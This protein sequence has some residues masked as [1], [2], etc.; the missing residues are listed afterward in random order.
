LNKNGDMVW[1]DLESV[2][3]GDYVIMTKGQ[4]IFGN[5]RTLSQSDAEWLGMLTGDGSM[6]MHNQ[7]KLTTADAHILKFSKAYCERKGMKWHI[8]RKKTVDGS[9]PKAVDLCVYNTGYRRYLEG[10]GFDYLL[11]IEKEIPPIIRKS[12][13]KVVAAFIRGLYETDGWIEPEK[14]AVC[15]GLSSEKLIDQLQVMLLNFG[16]VASKRVKPTLCHDSYILSIYRNYS[17]LFLKEIGLR[18]DGPKYKKLAKSIRLAKK[19]KK[20]VNCNKDV[21]PNQNMKLGLVRKALTTMLGLYCVLNYSKDAPIKYSTLRSWTNECYWRLP[22]RPSLKV[23]LD[24]SKSKLQDS[25]NKRVIAIID[26]MMELCS[27]KYYFDP[28][29]SKEQVMSE[30]YDFSIPESH[31]FV[32]Q[33]FINHN[34][35][36]YAR[37]IQAVNMSPSIVYVPSIDL[38]QQ[39]KDELSRFLLQNGKN[40]EIGSIGDGIFDPKDINVMTIQTAVRACG[41]EYVKYD[42]EDDTEEDVSL[43]DKRK[44]I[45]DLIMGAKAIWVDECVT[46]DTIVET[47]KGKVRIDQVQ[48]FGCQQVRSYDIEKKEVVWKN[49]TGFIPHEEREVFE[50][51]LY[52]GHVIRGTSDHLVM[53]RNGWRTIGAIQQ[54]D[55]LAIRD[56]RGIMYGSVQDVKKVDV[57]LKVYDINVADTHCF[58]AN[59]ILVHNCQ[60]A[61]SETV[62]TVSDYSVSAKYRYAGSATPYR[63]KNDD[64]LIDACFGK[65]VVDINASFL[66]N[67]KNKYLVPPHIYF[68]PIKGGNITGVKYQT[69]YQQSIVENPIRNNCIVNIAQKMAENGANILIL[70]RY[71]SHGNILQELL[72][73]SVFLNGAHSSKQRKEHLD[74][75]RQTA[76]GITIATSIFDEGVNVRSLDTLILGGSGKCVYPGTY[77]FTDRGMLT[78][79]EII[80]SS[81]TKPKPNEFVD[82][83]KPIKCDSMWGKEK[84]KSVFDGGSQNVYEVLCDNGLTETATGDHRLRIMRNGKIIYCKI[85]DITTDD[86]VIMKKGSMIFGNKVELP[87]PSRPIMGKKPNIIFPKKMT[88]MFA[89]FLGYFLCE[90]SFHNNRSIQ[91]KNVY[92]GDDKEILPMSSIFNEKIVKHF[93]N[94]RGGPD[95]CRVGWNYKINSVD[96]A[97]FLVDICGGQKNSNTTCVP[98]CIREAPLEFQSAFLQAVFDSEA[99]IDKNGRGIDICMASK[100]M[101]DQIQLMLL[102]MSISSIQSIRHIMG[103]D[104]Y[105]LVIS[106]VKNASRFMEL[107]G[108]M[109]KE[110]GRRLKE[111]AK[112][113][114]NPN[115]NIIP[116]IIPI[117]CKIREKSIVPKPTIEHRKALK[118]LTKL[119]PSN[120]KKGCQFTHESLSKFLDFYDDVN[121]CRTKYLKMIDRE[122]IEFVRIISVKKLDKKTQVYDFSVPHV[123]YVANGIINHNSST[124]ALQR[125]GRILR[126]YPGKEFANVID[127]EDHFKYMLAHSRK[128]K[129]I[130]ETEPAFQIS[131]LEMP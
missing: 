20:V 33:G 65:V 127:F 62:Q 63:D 111:T 125:I 75:I 78:V 122:D 60:H 88:K 106:N 107:I 11:S 42:D 27:D 59:D 100:Q 104:Y 70:V 56:D 34:S 84:M 81:G 26:D 94:N 22:S 12:P 46:G 102:N 101:I 77:I 21:T 121:D 74:E 24:W 126:P 98:L 17:G 36:M 16:I 89:K 58:F 8:V 86:F 38:L 48:Q 83:K 9:P 25:K 28:V 124:R 54:F 14:E 117:C 80:K 95:G 87:S 52:S 3:I 109:S 105:R 90:G 43:D 61:A 93:Y 15:I 116:G 44:D 128:R 68:V 35:S 4:R 112:K 69:I 19:N 110:K 31:S 5:N 72:P 92:R 51:L 2:E 7:V 49:I 47:E 6:T 118:F 37:L 114:Y 39:T 119:S 67:H 71:I 57:K 97:N 115:K 50:V 10:L 18:K 45:L 131:Y 120:N 53:T 64:I 1:K 73:D 40:A 96:I 103:K 123:H 79:D 130:Y 99:S 32:S 91:I 29:V 85:K 66:I 129:K 41:E 23:F 82:M 55:Q 113:N 76:K 30:N 13:K 108:F